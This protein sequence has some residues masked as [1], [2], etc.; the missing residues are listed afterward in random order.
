MRSIYFLKLYRKY[1]DIFIHR[2]MHQRGIN[3]RSNN[4]CPR[5]E[6]PG[7]KAAV[8]PQQQLP[9]FQRKGELGL[10]FTA[11]V[12][13]VESES[14]VIVL[15]KLSGLCPVSEATRRKTAIESRIQRK[16][17]IGACVVCHR[18]VGFDGDK[19]GESDRIADFGNRVM[20][21][22]TRTYGWSSGQCDSNS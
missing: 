3:S 14:I 10:D 7:W 21:M 9:L 15:A 22:K 11:L 8:R 13:G 16:S 6:E 1:A 5:N 4:V 2:G 12:K 17:Q 19:P 18:P 20:R